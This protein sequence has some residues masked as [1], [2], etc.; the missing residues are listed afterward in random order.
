MEQWCH[1]IDQLIIATINTPHHEGGRQEPMV[2]LSCS[3][4]VVRAPPSPHVLPSIA[5]ADLHDKLIR[6][7]KGEDSRITIEPHRE[8]RHNIEGRNLERDFESLAPAREV[9]TVDVMRPPSS[10]AGFGAV[11]RLHHIFGW[12]SGRASSDPIC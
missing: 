4:S 6:C 10:P 7:C 5:T 9:P 3:P 2:A 8:R 12:W 1:D 11:W